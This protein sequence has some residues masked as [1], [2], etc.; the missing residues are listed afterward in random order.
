M[1]GKLKSSK[2]Q[3][4]ELH[5]D[6]PVSSLGEYMNFMPKW[7]WKWSSP[8]CTPCGWGLLFTRQFTKAPW[9]FTAHKACVCRCNAVVMALLVMS[10]DSSVTLLFITHDWN[11]ECSF[12]THVAS[13]VSS[14]SL[15]LEI[16][17]HCFS[18]FTL[19]LFLHFS[20][21]TRQCSGLSQA[22]HARP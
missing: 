18:L 2:K 3:A 21:L 14:A 11:T 12:P 9:W 20:L 16:V 5:F 1:N 6:F 7:W 19:S 13:S 10:Q 17:Y 8:P 22:W 15:T 4:A